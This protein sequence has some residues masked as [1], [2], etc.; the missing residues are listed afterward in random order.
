MDHRKEA[1]LKDADRWEEGR[2]RA[3]GMVRMAEGADDDD[4]QE[5]RTQVISD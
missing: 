5:L 4:E 3:S 1:R 2:L